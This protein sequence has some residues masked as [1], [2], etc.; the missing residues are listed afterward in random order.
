MLIRIFNTAFGL[1]L[2]ISL[3]AQT[4]ANPSTITSFE[5]TAQRLSSN[6]NALRADF[7]PVRY[8]ERIYFSS[9]RSAVQGDKPLSKI[10][11]CTPGELPKIDKEFNLNKTSKHIACPTLM[12]DASR[13]Y[14]TI[15]SDEAMT[16]C[17]LWYRDR[18]FEGTWG[19]AVKLPESINQHG[20]NNTQPAIGF[21]VT[22]KKYVL[23]FASDRKG[24]KGKMDIWASSIS[25]DGKFG[26]PYCLPFNTAGDEVTPSY[27]QTAQTLYFSSNG[28]KGA[29]RLDVFSVKK[30]KSGNWVAPQSMGKPF[31]TAYDDL[32]FTYHEA[33]QTGY[34]ASD[35]PGSL[36]DGTI[37]GF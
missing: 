29:G 32:F 11:S 23:Y 24:G 6:V 7:A 12:P 14:F 27:N 34:L 35:R 20:S 19:P 21:D 22:Q 26:A 25:F 4:A 1:M 3:L 13:M 33:S 2:T 36:S 31:N 16:K 18:E 28:M 15:C 17:E 5:F 8:G 30:D 10:Y 37:E 9:T